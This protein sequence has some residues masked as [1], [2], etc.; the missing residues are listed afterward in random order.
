MPS[1][2]SQFDGAA[3]WARLAERVDNQ[4]RDI[5][6]LRSNMNTGFRNMESALNAISSDLRNGSKTQWPV[7]WSAIGVSFAIILAVGSQSLLPLRDAVSDLKADNEKFITRSEID[8]RAERV[9]Q[10]ILRIAGEIEDVRKNSVMRA[11]F[12]DLKRRFP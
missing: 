8:W 5:V 3:H 7:I 12:D 10:D 2:G 1:V 9:T 11:E 4:G 6:D